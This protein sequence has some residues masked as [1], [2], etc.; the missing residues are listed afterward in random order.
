MIPN[1]QATKEDFYHIENLYSVE[2]NQISKDV[3]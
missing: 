1:F 3:T 2:C